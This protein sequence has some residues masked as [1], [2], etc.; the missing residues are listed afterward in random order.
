MLLDSYDDSVAINIGSG[1]EISIAKL[2]TLVSKIV[3]FT[4]GISFNTD[5]P[6]GTPR[7]LLNSSKI[8][9]LGWKPKIN[10]EDG[11][12]LTYDWFLKHQTKEK[13]L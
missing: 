2:A 3:G 5:R 4:G 10:L 8:S 7:K 12:A 6:N 9:E 13:N 11:I 1:Q